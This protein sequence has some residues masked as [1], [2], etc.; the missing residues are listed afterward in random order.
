MGPEAVARA[1]WW[2]CKD[3]MITCA[4]AVA[5]GVGGLASSVPNG[6]NHG[7][8][9]SQEQ[10]AENQGTTT[11]VTEPYALPAVP[12]WVA[13]AEGEMTGPQPQL[14]GTAQPGSTVA[15]LL[16]G[17]LLGPVTTAENGT[18]TLQPPQALPLGAYELRASAERFGLRSAV[19]DPRAFSVGPT[20][21]QV[22]CGCRTSSGAESGAFLLLGV[23]L[24]GLS[25]RRAG[26]PPGGQAALAG[27]GRP[28]VHLPASLAGLPGSRGAAERAGT[29]R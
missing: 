5:S 4:S 24:A 12:T 9:P 20:A 28:G 8:T 16:N 2:C 15:V 23:L 29:R 7:A 17:Q 18:F 25:R 22:G 26:R 3:E 19:S 27:Q 14:Q 10:Q 11:S 6:G 21:L 1:E 13:P